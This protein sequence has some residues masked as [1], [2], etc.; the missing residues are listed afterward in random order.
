ML[1]T[2]SVR[3]SIWQ[4]ES[5][6]DCL[7]GNEDASAMF[8][9]NKCPKFPREIYE[10]RATEMREKVIAQTLERENEWGDIVLAL[11]KS[12]IDLVAAEER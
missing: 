2:P 5:K 7:V 8:E 9:K 12:V 1:Q 10:V 11:A 6:I 3:L 4:F